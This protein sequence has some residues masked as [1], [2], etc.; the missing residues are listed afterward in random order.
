MAVKVDVKAF[1]ELFLDGRFGGVGAQGIQT[2]ARS[3]P[4]GRGSPPLVPP[5][6]TVA[7]TLVG[8]NI[9]RL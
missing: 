5:T 9:C 8:R 2:T 3:T 1:S 7:H 4:T 6:T